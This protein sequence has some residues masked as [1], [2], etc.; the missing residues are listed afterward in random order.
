MN[1]FAHIIF[2]AII[3]IIY[4]TNYEINTF[5][6]KAKKY[7]DTNLLYFKN[8]AEMSS[9]ELIK[10][11]IKFYDYPSNYKF[12]NF[13]LDLSSTIIAN[14]ILYLQYKKNNSC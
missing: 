8:L 5:K 3:Y 14:S 9:E 12:D 4:K 1:C 6:Q 11:I 10:N 7:T 13:E 2:L